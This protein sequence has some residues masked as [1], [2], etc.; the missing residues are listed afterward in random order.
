[1]S[2]SFKNVYVCERRAHS[3]LAFK[4]LFYPPWM[5]L[6]SESSEEAKEHKNVV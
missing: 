6:V 5:H 1:M 4:L 3:D 2:V